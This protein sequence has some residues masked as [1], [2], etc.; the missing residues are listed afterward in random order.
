M[1]QFPAQVSASCQSSPAHYLWRDTQIQCLKIS[2]SI[3]TN[4]EHAT[5]DFSQKRHV[6][7]PF[8]AQASASTE[9]TLAHYLWRDTQIQLPK[10]LRP[11][12]QLINMQ[13]NIL[14][15][16]MLPFS[17]QASA[18]TQS[19][20]THL[21]WRDTQKLCFCLLVHIHVDFVLPCTGKC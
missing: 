9:N 11:L 5:P 16:R 15:L 6:D 10:S 1:L 14:L 21:L 12:V 3:G 7:L 13:V 8:P 17:A 19:N 18:S 20:P 4:Y 2:A